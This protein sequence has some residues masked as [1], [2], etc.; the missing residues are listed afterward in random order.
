MFFAVSFFSL[1]CHHTPTSTY[2][3]LETKMSSSSESP[4]DCIADDIL[5][6]WTTTLCEEVIPMQLFRLHMQFDAFLVRNPNAATVRADDMQRVESISIAEELPK[7]K[8]RVDRPDMQVF[9]FLDAVEHVITPPGTTMYAF[10]D[11]TPMS[12]LLKLLVD[13]NQARIQRI[14]PA[15]Q[16]TVAKLGIA[17]VSLSQGTQAAVAELIRRSGNRTIDAVVNAHKRKVPPA[18]AAAAAAAEAVVVPDKSSVRRVRAKQSGVEDGYN[19]MFSLR[20]SDSSQ[21]RTDEQRNATRESLLRER[22]FLQCV[23]DAWAQYMQERINHTPTHYRVHGK[24]CQ[25]PEPVR[26]LQRQMDTWTWFQLPYMIPDDQC[27]SVYMPALGLTPN[28]L[29]TRYSSQDYLP[30]CVSTW[31]NRKIQMQQQNTLYLQQ[32]VPVASFHRQLVCIQGQMARVFQLYL[33]HELVTASRQLLQCRDAIRAARPTT[34]EVADLCSSVQ[35]D[36][37]G[38][39]DVFIDLMANARQE[40]TQWLLDPT[41]PTAGNGGAG[42]GAGGNLQRMVSRATI[43][44]R[45]KAWGLYMAEIG[46]CTQEWTRNQLE[47]QRLEQIREDVEGEGEEVVMDEEQKSSSATTTTNV[48]L[49]TDGSLSERSSCGGGSPP[50][51]TVNPTLYPDVILKRARAQR[52]RIY[53]AADGSGATGSKD[54]VP[55]AIETLM[56]FLDTTNCQPT[57]W[58]SIMDRVSQLEATRIRELIALFG[59]LFVKT[60]APKW[61]AQLR[62]VLARAQFTLSRLPRSHSLYPTIVAWHTRV[63]AMTQRVHTLAYEDPSSHQNDTILGIKHAF[64]NLVVESDTSRFGIERIRW[65]L[66]LIQY[67][68]RMSAIAKKTELNDFITDLT[69]MELPFLDCRW[70]KESAAVFDAC[71]QSDSY[72]DA[73]D[74]L[75]DRRVPTTTTTTTDPSDND[76]PLHTMSRWLAGERGCILLPDKHALRGGDALSASTRSLVQLSFMPAATDESAFE[77]NDTDDLRGDFKRPVDALRQDWLNH[78]IHFHVASAT[79]HAFAAEHTES[80]AE[81]T[82]RLQT[83]WSAWLRRNSFAWQHDDRLRATLTM[84]LQRYRHI[85]VE[86]R[87]MNMEWP[88][89]ITRLYTRQL[90]FL[91]RMQCTTPTTQWE[92]WMHQILS[93]HTLLAWMQAHGGSPSR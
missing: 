53:A 61:L 10:L 60:H 23:L 25:Y 28:T 34:C 46:I 30:I 54:T 58:M 1:V 24:L 17:D 31:T 9:Q 91:Q 72:L 18:A 90:A 45:M 79:E 55:S 52:D 83:I 66:A 49:P 80:P 11:R 93:F 32:C 85:M 22:S 21:H 3:V 86:L 92:D 89:C 76:E 77:L 50:L 74:V 26:D 33:V 78:D 42:A 43:D 70:R 41:G 82:E 68:A 51:I 5:T 6:Q 64:R 73:I 63:F 88:A 56:E 40:Y 44:R 84:M 15:T 7:R 87:A 29:A 19:D 39:L 38:Y 12:Q 71:F 67:A 81:Q 36:T 27:K 65:I 2:N 37:A 47:F 13:H 57:E 62:I 48:K 4:P 35:L 69:S 75:G 8:M 59:K 16:T 14:L 20:A